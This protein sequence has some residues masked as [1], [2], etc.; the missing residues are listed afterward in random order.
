MSRI[1]PPVSCAERLTEITALRAEGYSVAEIADLLNVSPGA[2][3]NRIN[4]PDGAKQRKRRERYRGRCLTCG[5]P[6]D[7]SSGYNAP[8]YCV[9]HVNDS[10]EAIARFEAQTIWTRERIIAAI[11]WWADT[12]GEPP[13]GTDWNPTQLSNFDDVERWERAD[14]LIRE[15]VIPW[16]TS[17]VVRFG[18]WNAA[19]RA[20]GYEPRAAH[21]GAGNQYRRQRMRAT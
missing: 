15:R 3:R 2:V 21:G 20:A 13:S 5:A 19:I 11:R 16:F 4:D 1:A 17:V 8:R 18:T 10:P 14:R 9:D 7:G 6:T 12:Y